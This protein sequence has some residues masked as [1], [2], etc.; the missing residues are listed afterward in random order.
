VIPSA[1]ILHGYVTTCASTVSQKTAL[2]AWSDE[3]EAARASHR[4]TFRRRRDHLLELLRREKLTAVVPEGAFY[5]MVDVRS[6]GSSMDIAE[7]L[8]DFG[9]VT[10]PGSA[11]G[12]QSEGFLRVS[13][14]ADFAVLEEGVR[15]IAAGLKSR[16]SNG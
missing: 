5:T 8:L 15:R 2:A 3:A 14:C 6:Y 9:V 13:F 10:I 11:F 4:E 12:S 1:L 16:S 7:T